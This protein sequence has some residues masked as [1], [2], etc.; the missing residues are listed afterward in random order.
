MALQLE[1][2]EVELPL[3]HPFTIA[4]GT[5]TMQR[6]LIAELREEGQSGYGEA[7]ATE[8]YGASVEN[9]REALEGVRGLVEA[10]SLVTS[11]PEALL[12]EWRAALA[13]HPFALCALDGAVCDLWGKLRGEPV[14][15]LWGLE[16]ADAPKS[17]YTIGIDSIRV[18]IDKLKERPDWP[19]YKIKLGTPRDIEIVEA[20]RGHTDSAFRVD[21]NCGWTADET[22]THAPRLAELGVEFIEQPLVP[23]DEGQERVFAECALPVIADENCVAEFDVE[24]CVGRFHGVNIKLCKCGGPSIARRMALRAR[25]LGLKVMVGCMTETS[26][27]ISAAAQVGPL[28]DYLDLDGAVLLAED[29]ATGVRVEQGNIVFP[30]LPGSGIDLL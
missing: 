5:V 6:S 21:A 27:G 24:A 4:R 13:E 1:L 16:P 3:E 8:Y 17:S 11:D 18:M 29:A 22:V 2:H 19:I 14:H 7:P 10:Q 20:L 26:V 15:R 25:E 9:V 30:D 28:T 23:G 12:P